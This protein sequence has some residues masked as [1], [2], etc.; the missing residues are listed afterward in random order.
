MSETK[1]HIEKKV[2]E[3]EPVKFK[4]R[5]I[6]AVGRR[7]SATARVRLYKTGKG[8]VSVNEMNI[9]QYLTPVL[10]SI[11]KE[12]LK[13]SGLAKDLDFSILVR[14]G[15]K[16]G[17]AGAIRHGIARTL[18]EMEKDLRPA[19]KTKDL[20]TRDSRVKERKKPGLKKARRAPQW[21]KR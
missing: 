15:G 18:V 20:L 1:K 4:G 6:E 19:L 9:E 16:K 17:Q 7:K 5:Y 12:P 10:V 11:A 21:A 2:E 14:G 13:Y 8:I 3:A